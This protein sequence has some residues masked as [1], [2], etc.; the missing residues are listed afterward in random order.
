MLTAAQNG[1]LQP[2][3][4]MAASEANLRSR[5]LDGNTPLILALMHGP[6]TIAEYLVGLTNVDIYNANLVGEQSVYLAVRMGYDSVLRSLLS[7]GATIHELVAGGKPV[8]H[9]AVKL[10]LETIVNM[11]LEHGADIETPHAEGVTS[12]ISA[13]EARNEKMVRPLL[14]HGADPASTDPQGTAPLTVAC[15]LGLST[16]VGLLLEKGLRLIGR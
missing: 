8:L 9:T 15:Q 1:P 5:D 7:R 6:R 2:V 14:E 11:Q 3:Q 13:I 4:M 10:G 16:I 12:L